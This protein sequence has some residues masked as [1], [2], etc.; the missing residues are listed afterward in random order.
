ME[1]HFR[2]KEIWQPDV[3]IYEQVSDSY[4]AVDITIYSSGNAYVSLPRKTK[5]AC[6]MDLSAF[7]FDTQVC[8]FTIGPSPSCN[9]LSRPNVHLCPLTSTTNFAPGSWSYDGARVDVLPRR[10]D[11]VAYFE[12][13]ATAPDRYSLPLTFGFL[14]KH[15][16]HKPSPQPVLKRL[17]FPRALLKLC[18]RPR[19]IVAQH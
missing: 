17:P 5:F 13:P 2:N 14:L 18:T 4:L 16:S 15:R 11:K 3:I 8:R 1:V 6:P 10:I 7:P 19:L 9:P 12:D